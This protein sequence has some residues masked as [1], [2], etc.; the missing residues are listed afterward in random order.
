M[1]TALLAL[2]ETE[3]EV[4]VA[5]AAH[6]PATAAEPT[7]FDLDELFARPDELSGS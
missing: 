1:L 2:I 7:V 5:P 3:L 6:V 4:D